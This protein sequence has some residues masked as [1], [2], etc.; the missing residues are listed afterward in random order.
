[1][2]ITRQKG[3]SLVELLVAMVIGLFVAGI[4]TTMYISVLRANSTTVQLARL[5]Q[6][7][8]AALDIMS[9]D[10][11]RAGYVS[12]AEAAL[13]RDTSGDAVNPTKLTEVA[14]AS[15]SAFTVVS[16]ALTTTEKDLIP[17]NSSG[18]CIL[19]RYDANNDGVISG[20]SPEEIMG[21]KYLKSE[22]TIGF[23]TWSDAA[24]Q[25]S[26]NFV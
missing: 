18:D 9:R 13:S 10:I 8:Q 1:M 23:Q 11:Q 14:N 7:L 15:F 4:V 5:N 21:Y 3:F 6:D 26:Y 17:D 25:N 19:I 16:S 24:S 2:F 22:Q 12:G 20:T